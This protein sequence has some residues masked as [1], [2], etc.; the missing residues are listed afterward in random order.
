M[1]QR[2]LASL[3]FGLTCLHC[4]SDDTPAQPV[5]QV[6]TIRE[7]TE[8]VLTCTSNE[9]ECELEGG[10]ESLVV[11]V[12]YAGLEFDQH[13]SIPVPV[14]T[15]L[16]D[17]AALSGTPGF[18]L[19][20]PTTLSFVTSAYELPAQPID[21]LL[22]RAAVATGYQAEQGGFR[23][24]V[25]PVELEVDECPET[26]DCT[27]ARGV[28]QIHLTARAFALDGAI[29]S[30]VGRIQGPSSTVTAEAPFEL[31]GED[32][33]REARLTL[34]VPTR[35]TELRVQAYLATTSPSPPTTIKLTKPEVEVE[36]LEC[37][38]S[39]NCKLA[40][41]TKVTVAVTAPSD[42]RN[43]TAQLRPVID[44]IL[45]PAAEIALESN[46]DELLGLATLTLPD[47]GTSWHAKLLIGTEEP[48]TTQGVTLTEPP[49]PD[50]D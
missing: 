15:L 17:G 26:A 32:I 7:G 8:Q 6:A 21:E 47:K 49:A 46:G 25:A 40:R 16:A 31:L 1:K 41:G 3:L 44:G 14:L 34:D 37:T 19:S 27:L 18:R 42:L 22:V 38:A 28:G 48:W 36:L 20:D 50:E 11:K 4:S 39:S 30:V 9:A 35:G 24:V 23:V 12:R 33:Q 45:Q 5:L 13:T 2:A 29:A 10:V 43:R